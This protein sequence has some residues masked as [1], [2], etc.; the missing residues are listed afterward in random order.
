MR[1]SSRAAFGLAWKFSPQRQTTYCC[2]KKEYS[3]TGVNAMEKPKTGDP[4]K[5]WEHSL[6][7]SCLE[8]FGYAVVWEQPIFAVKQRRHIIVERDDVGAYLPATFQPFFRHL[9]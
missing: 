1:S 6:H 8:V 7:E 4:V 5:K 2:W 9:T 3:V